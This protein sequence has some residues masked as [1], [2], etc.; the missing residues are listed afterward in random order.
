MLRVPF[1]CIFIINLFLFIQDVNMVWDDSS[2]SG[3][4]DSLDGHI[5]SSFTNVQLVSSTN[6]SELRVALRY[7]R[8]FILKS[9]SEKYRGLPI[10]EAQLEKEFN[11]SIQMN[12]PNIVQTVGFEF[13]PG[14]GNAIV[15]EFVDGVTLN[16]WLNKNPSQHLRMDV[17]RQLL[18]A[19]AYIHSHQVIHRD[20]KP[21]NILVTRNGQ[22]VKVIDFGLSD[23]DSY[24]VFK[25]PAGT[26]RYVS[27]EQQQSGKL[28]DLRS[29]IYSLGVILS[30]LFPNKYRAVAKRCCALNPSDRYDNVAQLR[31]ALGKKGVP[32]KLVL[33][34][35]FLVSVMLVGVWYYIGQEYDTEDDVLVVSQVDSVETS[36]V[37]DSPKVVKDDAIPNV[38]VKKKPAVRNVEQTHSV[39]SIKRERDEVFLKQKAKYEEIKRV[40]VCSEEL[41]CKSNEVNSQ[42]ALW[43]YKRVLDADF[44]RDEYQVFYETWTDNYLLYRDAFAYRD[45]LSSFNRLYSDG[46]ITESQR[47]SFVSMTGDYQKY[48]SSLGDSI[49]YWNSKFCGWSPR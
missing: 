4:I 34:A 39:E 24:A 2:S 6:H 36:V 10:Y 48:M 33:P 22:H 17:M 14:L 42:F 46:R 3:V 25:Q 35:L 29:D 27:P 12:H 13:V 37:E 18:D 15:M 20:L 44:K 16:D 47:D 9:L 19:V 11:I 23:T 7:G 40:S 32:W 21:Q 45:S 38:A 31:E 49:I 30:D 5:D 26:K 1:S 41:L 28:V 43:F 8:K